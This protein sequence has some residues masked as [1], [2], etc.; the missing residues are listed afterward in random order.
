MRITGSGQLS[1]GIT[2]D[3]D[4][5][6]VSALWYIEDLRDY[7]DVCVLHQLQR[8]LLF[9]LGKAGKPCENE[10]AR[11]LI[12][13]HAR[14][15]KLSYQSRPV[16]DGLE[17]QQ[18][19]G[20]VPEQKRL[21]TVKTNTT[22]WGN[23]HKQIDVNVTL[24]PCIDPIVAEHKSN[25]K[26]KAVV[27]EAVDE[28][29]DAAELKT[30]DATGKESVRK[31]G[32][33][34]RREV[35]AEG[36]G[37]SM[38]DW[39]AS[40]HL[41]AFLQ[42][43][44]DAKE[45][46]EKNDFLTGAQG[47]QLM[48]NLYTKSDP[49]NGML[50]VKKL[51]RNVTY[52]ARRK[53]KV[54]DLHWADLCEAVQVGSMVLQTE[55][56]ERFFGTEEYEKPSVM[57]LVQLH[58]SKQMPIAS[59]LGDCLLAE[60]KAAYLRCL[61]ANAT[62][63]APPQK[64]PPKK[65]NNS[66][67]SSKLFSPPTSMQQCRGAGGED[68]LDAVQR[69]VEEWSVLPAAVISSHIDVTTN[70]INEFSLMHAIKETFPLHYTTFRQT[71]AHISHEAD[72]E[73]LFSLAKGLTHWNMRP[74]FLRVLTLLKGCTVFEPTIEDVWSAYKDKYGVHSGVE[75]ADSFEDEIGSC[76]DESE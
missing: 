39:K 32:R 50:V 34:K 30:K 15:V 25:N 54:E 13:K 2:P 4:S 41:V 24:Q 56:K 73:S 31:I 58:M 20:N 59:V 18:R 63:L 36:V 74:G 65:A 37:L 17:E 72:V 75:L 35:M 3:G 42:A 47:I 64:S 7:V 45:V 53:R 14:I 29:G 51:P 26:G 1:V 62:M 12:R 71:A 8:A 28:E 21:R 60:S 23:T 52:S 70:M 49:E 19:I 22:R 33:V 46:I 67:Q 9:A 76:G 44:F 68:E 55:L 48:K 6:G 16:I 40:T 11:E 10:H 66:S 57:R 69:E 43:P 5:A 27:D 61:R 38:T